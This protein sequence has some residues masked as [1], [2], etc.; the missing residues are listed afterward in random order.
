MPV[1]SSFWVLWLMF[2]ILAKERCLTM[3]SNLSATTCFP[4]LFCFARRI[5]ADDISSVQ[6]LQLQ[7]SGLFVIFS[8]AMGLCFTQIKGRYWW[9]SPKFAWSFLVTHQMGFLHTRTQL[10]HLWAYFFQQSWHI[11]SP[12]QCSVSVFGSSGQEKTLSE[13]RFQPLAVCFQ[14]LIEDIIFQSLC[15][16]ISEKETAENS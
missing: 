3:A 15:W 12:L 6:T 1:A 10:R 4:E 2:E 5:R 13:G 16:K 7:S 14:M 8:A 11:V 9:C